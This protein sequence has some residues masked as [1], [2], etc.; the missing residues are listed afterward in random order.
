VELLAKAL[1]RK[2]HQ[3]YETIYHFQ[4]RPAHANEPLKHVDMADQKTMR[5][6]YLS[7]DG[8]VYESLR[9]AM[10]IYLI[11]IGILHKHIAFGPDVDVAYDSLKRKFHRLQWAP[12]TAGD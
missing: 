2:F 11:H 5:A 9:T 4:S 3:W 8:Q 1:H 12:E 6:M 7:S 10:T